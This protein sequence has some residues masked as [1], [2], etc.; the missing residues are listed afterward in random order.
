MTAQQAAEHCRT[1]ENTPIP[2][3]G[4]WTWDA[5]LGAWVPAADHAAEQ[6]DEEH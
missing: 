6:A 4:S 5:V 2:G 3:G 1:P